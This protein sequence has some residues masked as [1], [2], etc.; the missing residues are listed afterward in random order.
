MVVEGQ[1]GSDAVAHLVDAMT[2]GH[3]TD[4]MRVGALWLRGWLVAWL[5]LLAMNE[6]R[7]PE[8][9]RR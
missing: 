4:V 2:V 9:G 3:L 8:R 5:V 1:Q 6:R 7:Q